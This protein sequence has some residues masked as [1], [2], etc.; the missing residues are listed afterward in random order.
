[1]QQLLIFLKKIS[2]YRYSSSLRKKEASNP[3]DESNR[4]RV[5][6]VEDPMRQIQNCG[7]IGN[8]IRPPH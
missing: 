8:H 3:R 5:M 6:Q 2:S 1:M 7:M 4:V